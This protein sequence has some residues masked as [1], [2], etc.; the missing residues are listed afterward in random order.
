MKTSSSPSFSQ[1]RN[2][3]LSLSPRLLFLVFNTLI[4]VLIIGSHKSA[5]N[6]DGKGMPFSCFFYGVGSVY[7]DAN[8]ILE[9]N[10]EEE[11]DEDEG[12]G[13]GCAS[14]GYYE[15]DDDNGRDDDDNDDWDDYTNEYDEN[16]A[17]RIEDFIAKVNE[18]WREER[19]M[20]DCRKAHKVIGKGFPV[21]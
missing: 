5:V 10:Y 2:R 6:E 3:E 20:Q 7:D 9:E 17:R 16:L 13:D 19:L 1:H 8:T 18:G 21:S 14:D 4:V 15:D 11:D 12:D